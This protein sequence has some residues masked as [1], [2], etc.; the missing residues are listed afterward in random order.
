MLPKEPVKFSLTHQTLFA[1]A[2]IYGLKQI[3]LLV[4]EISN[5]VYIL[6]L[7][8]FVTEFLGGGEGGFL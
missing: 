1:F 5:T 7:H 2:V 3:S 4:T 8:I 6:L